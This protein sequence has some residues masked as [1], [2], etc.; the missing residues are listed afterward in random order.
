MNS[1]DK[2]A[3]AALSIR[4]ITEAMRDEIKK[5]EAQ[6]EMTRGSLRGQNTV[7]VFDGRAFLQVID[8][9]AGSFN[10]GGRAYNCPR[11]S[12]SDAARIAEQLNDVNKYPQYSGKVR[13]VFDRDAMT[14]EIETLKSAIQFNEE[15]IA[16]AY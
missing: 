13:A 6:I 3:K 11:Y 8:R 9:D 12:P 7:I 14:D 10:F 15:L 2:Q 1:N 4:E 16:G 5:L